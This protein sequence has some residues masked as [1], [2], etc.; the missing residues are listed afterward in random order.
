MNSYYHYCSL[1]AFLK[2]ISTREIW[3]TNIFCTNDSAEYRWLHMRAVRVLSNW[4]QR[5]ET[6]PE[7]DEVLNSWKRKVSIEE[8]A[9]LYCCCLSD[10]GDLLGQWRAYADDGRGVALGLGRDFL[11]A[12]HTQH[13]GLR[14]EHVIYDPE[15]QDGIVERIIES[16][17]SPDGSQGNNLPDENMDD[18]PALV[19]KVKVGYHAAAC[20]HPSFREERE[21][22]II[23]DSS[24]P[25]KCE[26][27]KLSERR[28]RSRCGKI[29][30]YYALDLPTDRNRFAI[31]EVV[32][33][34]RNAWKHNERPA[35]DLLAQS[36]YDVEKIVFWPS[37]S[38]Y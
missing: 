34:P 2:I 35:R 29:I 9:D 24:L 8:D 30:P 17:I 19:G 37:E 27:A 1:D 4:R 32:F 10:D 33:G 11:N 13:V 6:T 20:K 12:I 26:S 18:L 25:P 14:C 23:Y 7:A 36:G 21:V 31:S 15:S 28:F 16:L 38:T 22:R 5:N 3:L